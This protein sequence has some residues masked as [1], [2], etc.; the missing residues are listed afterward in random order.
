MPTTA[1]SMGTPDICS[2]MSTASAT[3][4]A[5]R[6]I[7]T[8]APLRTPLDATTPT[9]KTRRPV[10][11]RSAAAQQTLVVPI[12]SA[13]TR[14]GRV[15]VSVSECSRRGCAIQGFFG[16]KPQD[17]G[18]AS[19]VCHNML[20]VFGRRSTRQRRPGGIRSTPSV[21]P[22]LT[23]NRA[24]SLHLFDETLYAAVSVDQRGC[25]TV[26]P[27]GCAVYACHEVVSAEAR[28]RSDLEDD[29][30]A[31]VAACHLPERR[32]GIR[33]CVRGTDERSQSA[34]GTEVHEAAQLSTRA[35]RRS[36][37]RDAAIEDPV[38][39]CRWVRTARGA[40]HDHRPARS[41]R[42]EA[43]IP[44]WFA[45]SVDHGINAD[46]AGRADDRPGGLSLEREG[47]LGA[48]VDCQRPLGLIARCRID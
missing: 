43:E 7:S 3:A 36:R 37:D 39:L 28:P 15:T 11:S 29:L 18:F 35:H 38:E 32:C 22:C 10:L 25:A 34:G 45:D 40:G 26:A 44:C 27:V 12:S 46:S 13:N 31:Q 30:A 14:R 23:K 2:A 33:Q 17:A 19:P 6:S 21:R 16:A 8:T 9:P 24:P 47:G 20:V 41:H 48:E 1:E 5:A 42:L 4:S